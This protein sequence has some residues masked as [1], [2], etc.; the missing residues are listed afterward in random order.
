MCPITNQLFHDPVTLDTGQTYERGAIKEWLDRG[1]VSC[2]ITRQMLKILKLP[3]TNIVL[4][5][6]VDK[7][8]DDH[9]EF[10][11]EFTRREPMPRTPSRRVGRGD[12]VE[13]EVYSG[14][15]SP[16]SRFDRES[17]M[18]DE[19]QRPS[20]RFG[21]KVAPLPH[22]MG[23]ETSSASLE[24][25]LRQLM[26]AVDT[27]LRTTDL[28]Q[29]ERASLA[30]AH[31]WVESKC[32][33]SIAASLSTADIVE[34]LME[35]LASSENDDVL[36]SIVCLLADL[37]CKDEST[38]RTIMTADPK[39]ESIVSVL[40][41]PRVPQAV[42]LLHLLKVPASQVSALKVVPFLV[43]VVT[44]GQLFIPEGTFSL[45]ISPKAAAV[46]LLEQLVTTLDHRTNMSNAE[47][48]VR[49]EGLPSLMER[50]EVKTLEEKISAVA[51]LYSCLQSDGS[52]RMQMVQNLRMSNL[53]DLLHNSK[54]RVR[55]FAITFIAELIR[56]NRWDP[57]LPP[58]LYQ[59]S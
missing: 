28:A 24:A 49:A 20:R 46:Y 30:I 6:L 58:W 27:L 42:V 23:D 59:I 10:L 55:N 34:G 22:S 29:C 8:K 4:K 56:L 50:L 33:D 14:S 38:R 44:H 1:N 2:P 54:E 11:G 37:I 19:M 47:V 32:D 16:S 31:V 7:W 51:V 40:R 26:S 57:C 18:N 53:T 45:S 36:R 17:I 9:P 21:Q 12:A 13:L 52:C 5:R 15:S 43:S 39:L 35:L 25:M 48:V 41:N 3:K